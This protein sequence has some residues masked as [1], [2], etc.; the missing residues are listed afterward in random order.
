[1]EKG[2]VVTLAERDFGFIRRVGI[3]ENLFFH[4]D[5]LIGITFAE[6]RAGDSL[7][8]TVTESRK[9]PYATQVTRI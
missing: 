2:K 8:F 5:A 9:G 7:N 4:A 3:K 6:L 1:M